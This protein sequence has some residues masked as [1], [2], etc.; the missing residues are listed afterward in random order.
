MPFEQ[1]VTL[2]G[3]AGARLAKQ[4]E[5]A[6]AEVDLSLPQYRILGLLSEGSAALA[7][8]LA[9]S[10]P[11]VPS[12]VDGL[13]GRSLVERHHETADRR[14]VSHILTGE[15]RRLIAAADD[16]VHRRLIQVAGYLE[17]DEADQALRGLELW[18]VALDRFRAAKANKGG[19]AQ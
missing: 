7:G 16:A 5:V 6:L 19:G 10:K 3:R 14:R 18:Q 13:V 15:G 9:V 17:P 4:L 1:S 12:L 2:G 8:Q 11:S